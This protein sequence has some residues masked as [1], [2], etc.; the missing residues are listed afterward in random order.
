VGA[1]DALTVHQYAV[2]AAAIVY[3]V[4]PIPPPDFSVVAGCQIILDDDVVVLA[5]TESDAICNREFKVR[6]C[7]LQKHKFQ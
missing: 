1:S 2:G 4:I 5:T 3:D 7:V 6:L